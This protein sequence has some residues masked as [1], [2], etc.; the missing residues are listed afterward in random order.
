MWAA[1]ISILSIMWQRI[2]Q[3]Y[4]FEGSMGMKIGD[5]FSHMG[6]ELIVYHNIKKTSSSILKVLIFCINFIELDKLRFVK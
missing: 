4:D 2:F 1:D 6:G 3:N 5:S